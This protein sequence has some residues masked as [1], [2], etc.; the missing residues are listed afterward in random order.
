MLFINKRLDLWKLERAPSPS[1]GEGW[2]GG[3]DA[4]TSVGM[5]PFLIYGKAPG[6]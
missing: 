4:S 3:E 2:D 5:T 6:S 1:M